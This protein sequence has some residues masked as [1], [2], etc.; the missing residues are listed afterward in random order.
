MIRVYC[1]I[2]FIV[3]FLAGPVWAK[4]K[5]VDYFSLRNP[6]LSQLPVVEII[7]T[8]VEQTQQKNDNNSMNQPPVVETPKEQPLVLPEL[9]LQG[10]VWGV[11]H[12]IAIINDQ[13]YGVGQS[14]LGAEVKTISKKGIQVTYGGKEFDVSLQD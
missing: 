9:K 7:K 4:D 2:V 11:K 3:S 13:S 5:E 12:P 10:I 14:V 8:P 1:Y 6:F